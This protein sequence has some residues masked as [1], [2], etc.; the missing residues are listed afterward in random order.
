MY[1]FESQDA[2]VLFLNSIVGKIANKKVKRRRGFDKPYTQK[3]PLL[4]KEIK[5]I[6]GAAFLC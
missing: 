6:S 2:F 4:L 5:E 3:M 1:R